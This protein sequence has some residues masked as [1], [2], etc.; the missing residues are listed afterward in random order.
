MRKYLR[1][2]ETKSPAHKK[3][4]AFA[5]SAGITLSIFC[6]WSMFTFSLLRGDETLAVESNVENLDN[7]SNTASVSNA[8]APFDTISS[9]IGQSFQ[10]LKDQFRTIKGSIKSVDLDTRYQNMRDDALK[11]GN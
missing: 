10:A 1:N 5:V 3:R 6:F 8:A 11:S 9:S 2:L 4:F 7:R